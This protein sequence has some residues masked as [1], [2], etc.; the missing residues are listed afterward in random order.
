MSFSG[1]GRIPNFQ[2]KP[3]QTTLI[4]QSVKINYVLMITNNSAYWLSWKL[5]K[6]LDYYFYKV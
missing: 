5:A 4:E 1:S 2:N 3:W 6:S